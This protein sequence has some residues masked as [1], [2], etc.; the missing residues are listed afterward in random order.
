VT[1]FTYDS[2]G[3]V[4][5]VTDST[6]RDVS[7]DYSGSTRRLTSFTDAAGNVTAYAYDADKNLNRIT[8]PEGRVTKIGYDSSDR[9]TSVTQV[10]DTV[11]DTGPTTTF[12]YQAFSGSPLVGKTTVTDARSNAT[13]YTYDPRL[14]VTSV[15][16][17]RNH[18]TTTEWNSN[19]NVTELTDAETGLT[20]F[21]YDT[22][23]NVTKVTSPTEGATQFTY[24]SGQ[25]Q[26]KT[27]KDA[28]GNIYEYGYDSKRNLTSVQGPLAGTSDD[29]NY[30]YNPDGTID[31]IED[32]LGR[33]TDHGYDADGNL[34]SIDYPGP[35]GTETLTYDA[36]SRVATRTDGKGQTTTFT[37]DA[38]D[39]LDTTTFQ[40]GS[41]VNNDYD[42][43]GNLTKRT[44]PT[45]V[46][47]FRY[48]KRGLLDQ[49]KFPGL[50][51]SDFTYD[52]VGNLASQTIPGLGT[53]TY[54][55]YDA[56]N[57]LKTMTEPGGHQTTFTYDD[58]NRRETTTYPNGVVETTG[59]DASGRI[60]TVGAEK[61]ATTF[62]DFT[63]DYV[64][65]ANTNNPAGDTELRQSVTDKD[66]NETSYTYDPMNRLKKAETKTSGG[67][68]TLK[69]E[70]DYDAVGNRT[71][72][73]RN[74]TTVKKYDYND[75]DQLTCTYSGTDCNSSGDKVTYTYDLNG[76]QTGNSA[77]QALSYNTVNQTTS[78]KKAGGT[79]ISATYAGATQDERIT[80]GA[81]AYKDNALGTIAESEGATT[82]YFIRDDEGKLISMRVGSSRYYYL[83]DG[84]GSVA[85]LT[86]S[87]G[88]S[89]PSVS[90]SY[91]AYGKMTQTGSL[92][93]PFR[94]AAGYFD[95]DT[96][97]YKFGTRYYEPTLGRWTQ[98]DPVRGSIGKPESL[99][100]YP[101]SLNDPVNLV[102]PGGDLPFLLALG[103]AAVLSSIVASNVVFVSAGAGS[104]SDDP[105]TREASNDA[106][107]VTA[108]YFNWHQSA[109]GGGPLDPPYRF[110]PPRRWGR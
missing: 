2:Y 106:L 15:L 58:D 12:S 61:G 92:F 70:Y 100:P 77:G 51:T 24:D 76:S 81:F 22:G 98:V 93:N 54:D 110:P 90:Y 39:R 109:R 89:T 60:E 33:I 101:Y 23:N 102:D 68:T 79:A 104:L 6:G 9:V 41:V 47:E 49:K 59:Y 28:Q 95:K 8:T 72:E 31:T 38:M 66:N 74:T 107:R 103:G 67:T 46:Y 16:D 94:F 84:L 17:A 4:D 96:D 78:L 29:W 75:S 53:V 19:S 83:F 1:T 65:T 3:T 10:T 36:L 45:G 7:Y 99:A 14:R 5:T 64:D 37:Y 32:P 69:L 86:D 71:K 97:L 87:T 85:A 30:N 11:N 42:K 48:D 27:K 44:D 34:T 63:Y 13:V 20:V 73:T 43:D 26:P 62:T 91:E 80:A 88:S 21:E 108:P 55:L 35:R 56:T 18:T 52:S 50:T 57:N 105:E 40:G 25:H 82:R